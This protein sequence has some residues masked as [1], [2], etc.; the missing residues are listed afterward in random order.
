MRYD[1]ASWGYILAVT[2]LVQQLRKRN[3]LTVWSLVA[4]IRPQYP[5]LLLVIHQPGKHRFFEIC[6]GTR[7]V[8]A[9]VASACQLLHCCK[10]SI[11][12]MID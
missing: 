4:I 12:V 5:A 3:A 2:D 8:L 10:A 7:V 9:A 1:W 6:Y 11:L